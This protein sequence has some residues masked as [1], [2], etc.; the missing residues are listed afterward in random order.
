MLIYRSVFQVAREIAERLAREHKEEQQKREK[1]AAIAP[2]TMLTEEFAVRCVFFNR[3]RFK[4]LWV[5]VLFGLRT[6]RLR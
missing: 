1:G 6:I 4:D 3:L 2:P 5:T